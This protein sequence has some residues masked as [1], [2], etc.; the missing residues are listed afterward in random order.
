MRYCTNCGTKSSDDTAK[1]CAACGVKFPVETQGDTQTTEVQCE[2][3]NNVN[4][5]KRNVLIFLALAILA[6]SIIIVCFTAFSHRSS[7]PTLSR[8]V[9][10]L[11]TPIENIL[12]DD[13]F[14]VK[15]I[16]DINIAKSTTDDVFGVNG[17]IVI[18]ILEDEENV[19]IV[20]WQS[21]DDIRLTTT[22]INTFV[23]N[24]IDIYG[25]PIES[26]E[27]GTYLWC[28][29][30]LSVMLKTEENEINMTFVNGE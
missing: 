30:D 7:E 13:D 10:L 20:T 25:K 16:L 17:E 19:N 9:E 26:D 21:K 11:G 12:E 28:D 27:E 22:E 6:G 8:C 18:F 14:T 3:K 4:N 23:D 24:V 15:G 29:D 5:K 1:F 2:N